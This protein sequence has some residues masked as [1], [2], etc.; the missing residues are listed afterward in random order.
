MLAQKN[1]KMKLINKQKTYRNRHKD[2]YIVI[3][4]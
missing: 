1:Y 2:V 4:K 3:F